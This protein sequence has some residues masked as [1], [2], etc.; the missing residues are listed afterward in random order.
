MSARIVNLVATL[1]VA[2]A[3]TT[4]FT[5]QQEEPRRDWIDPATGHRIVRLSD[6]PG[7]STLY[8]HDNAFSAA[9]DKLMLR[10]PKGI[11]VV[12][13]AKI[14]TR[15]PQAGLCG[16]AARGGYFARRGREIYLAPARRQLGR[17]P[18]R[19]AVKAVNVDTR[20]VREMPHARGLINADETLSVVKNG[21]AVDRDGKYP[22]PRRP[23]PI[24]RSSSACFPASG[25]RI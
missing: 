21:N 23:R 20:A 12:D 7:S 9:G 22:T 6:E 16:A 3:A 19:G 1:V 17:R 2:A 13:V 8:F 4:G 5:A 11:A 25:W 10:T 15:R 18:G 14:G 24:F